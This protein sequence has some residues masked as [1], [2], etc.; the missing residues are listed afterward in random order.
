MKTANLD[1][2]LARGISPGVY[3][4]V[5]EAAGNSYRGLLY[6]GINSLTGADC[7][8]VHL[9]DFDAS[10]VGIELAVTVGDFIRPPLRAASLEE[11]AAALRADLK[12]VQQK[13]ADNLD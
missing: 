6:F 3:H 13:I 11:L 5:V 1:A 12:R 4:C 10:L 9:L 7:L 2:A 8:E